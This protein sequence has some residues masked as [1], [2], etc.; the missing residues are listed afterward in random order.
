M[1]INAHIISDP[2]FKRFKAEVGAGAME[3]I[4]RL[5]A[6]CE[7]DQRGEE[8][9]R[10]DDLILESICCWEGEPGRLATA[11]KAP[12]G[13]ELGFVDVRDGRYRVVG[14]EERNN[15][16]VNS[17]K[18]GVKGG[19][20]KAT[21]DKSQ[22]QSGVTQNQSGVTQNR[23]GVTQNRSGVSRE[24]KRREEKSRVEESGGF[25]PTPPAGGVPRISPSF[26]ASPEEVVRYGATCTPPVPSHR[27][28]QFWAHYEGQA[29][30]RNGQRVWTTSKGTVIS[31][32]QE[33]LRGWAFND[34]ETSQKNTARESTAVTARLQAV[35]RRLREIGD[36]TGETVVEKLRL[37]KERAA[38]LTQQK[39]CVTELKQS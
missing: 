32:W 38:L 9:G 8:L 5:Y 3:Y 39:Q 18:N 13:Q 29:V 28:L 12:F 36:G 24:E 34:G 20:P 37:E 7:A 14:W 25:S 4:V 26:P 10:I 16:L 23:S 15:R 11:L 33:R 1:V 19:R 17:W 22:N 27:C 30:I 35:E 6:Y 21:R 2:H 31:N